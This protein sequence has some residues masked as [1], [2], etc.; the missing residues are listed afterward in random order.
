MNIIAL[1]KNHVLFLL[2]DLRY[3]RIGHYVL[4][5]FLG[6]ALRPDFPPPNLNLETFIN[7]LLAIISI[8]FSILFSIITNNLADLEIDK[9]SNPNRPHITGVI[10]QRSYLKY[11][12]ISF[13]FSVSFSAMV[14]FEV[15][16]LNFV[17]I[18]L[19]FIYSIPPFRLK[20]IPILSKMIIGINSVILLNMGRIILYP[21][22]FFPIL[23]TTL[24]AIGVG[25]I[26]NFIDI[27]DYEG[28]LAGGIKTI[29]VLIGLKISK[30]IIGLCFIF[31][32][33]CAIILL[34]PYFPLNFLINSLL[35]ILFFIALIQYYFINR[36]HFEERFIFL[37]NNFLIFLI[38]FLAL[39]F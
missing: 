11:A 21:N 19:Y 29:P 26:S 10:D 2:K 16:L 7:F 38:G 15:F 35:P 20:R 4:F 37:I 13:F 23:P 9:I 28:D 36:N 5:I 12:F 27:K 24:L 32:Y 18:L 1:K 25:I 34:Y 30:K 39:S 31:I 33:P 22:K 8:V 6:A 3:L 14:N 17:F